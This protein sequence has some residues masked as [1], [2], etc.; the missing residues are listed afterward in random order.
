MKKSKSE[1]SL[2]AF[3]LFLNYLDKH[4]I[5]ARMLIAVCCFYLILKTCTNEIIIL[6]QAFKLCQ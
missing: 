3:Q 2:E 6:I 4:K 1:L 5:Q